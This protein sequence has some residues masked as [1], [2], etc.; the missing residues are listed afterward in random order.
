MFDSEGTVL[1]VGKA[2]N[3]KVDDMDVINWPLKF[4]L[5]QPF[6]PENKA[7]FIPMQYLD[8]IPLAITEHVQALIK[9]IHFK[10][11]LNQSA[12]SIYG[13]AKVYWCAMQIDRR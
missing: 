2:K 12:Q 6:V 9:G 8:A 11:I 3:L 5:L 10:L 13:L 7:R 1:Y 4:R